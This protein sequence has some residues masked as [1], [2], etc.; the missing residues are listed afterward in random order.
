MNNSKATH[1]NNLKP[2]RQARGIARQEDM[3]NAAIE[4]F[5]ERDV[6]DVSFKDIYERAGLLPGSAYRFF[7]NLN[8]IY[9]GLSKRFVSEIKDIMTAPLDFEDTQD[10]QSTCDKIIQRVADYYNNS[11]AAATFLAGAKLP[12]GNLGIEDRTA[13]NN[14]EQIYSQIFY[15][16][17]I[18][19]RQDV[20]LI[21]GRLVTQI[22]ALS[23]FAHGHITDELVEEAKVAARGYLGM[24]LPHKLP[25]KNT[26]MR[27]DDIPEEDGKLFPPH[28]FVE[29]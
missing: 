14:L 29:E 9:I 13:G 7:S 28:L 24:Y 20:F 17:S 15:L 19:N 1:P 6:E 21:C 12:I 2:R 27:Q 25:R 5:N 23:L 11:P 18:P 8:D 3:L 22:Y 16:P 10:W 26:T 4:L